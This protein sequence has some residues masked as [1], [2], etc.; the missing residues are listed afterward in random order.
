MKSYIHNIRQTLFDILP[1][2]HYKNINYI[3]MN[4]CKSICLSIPDQHGGSKQKLMYNEK[5]FR[6]RFDKSNLSIAIYTKNKEETCIL[7]FIDIKHRYAYIHDL[8]YYPGCSKPKTESGKE[9][10]MVSLK[11]L[12]KNKDKYEIDRVVLTDNSVK[13]IKGCK[14][15]IKLALNYFLLTGNTWYGSV[16]FRPYD[17]IRNKPENYMIKRYEE[18][19]EKLKHVKANNYNKFLDKFSFIKLNRDV[20]ISEYLRQTMKSYG[21]KYICEINKMIEKLY[22]KMDLTS[23]HQT[24]FHLDL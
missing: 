1:S 13:Y 23:F 22:Y 2:E 6:F 17:L 19:Q 16:G 5:E 8:S 15:P 20:L 9:I 21:D 14:D 18:V 12:K 7:I 24:I 11:F 3:L 4:T 10:L